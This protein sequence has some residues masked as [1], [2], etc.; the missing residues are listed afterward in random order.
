MWLLSMV[1]DSWSSAMVLFSAVWD[2]D[3]T[4]QWGWEK[5]CAWWVTK[6]MGVGSSL[7]W[8]KGCRNRWEWDWNL[9]PVQTSTWDHFC[10]KLLHLQYI[11]GVLNDCISCSAVSIWHWHYWGMC[12]PGSCILA[13]TSTGEGSKIDACCSS[14][15][16]C[17]VIICLQLISN[18]W[19]SL[20]L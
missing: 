10:M 16:G 13:F 18:L 15:T 12:L 4:H 20:K 7:R 11:S 6:C 1:I 3:W 8:C 5:T 2:R 14:Q 19:T 9:T 17:C